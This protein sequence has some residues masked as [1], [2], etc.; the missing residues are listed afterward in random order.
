MESAIVILVLPLVAALGWVLAV[1]AREWGPHRVPILCYHR[2]LS[3]AD[4]R[5]GLVRD[6]ERMWVVYDD[7][8]AAQMA[9][10]ARA[11]FTPI[12]LDDYVA[13]RAGRFPRPPKPVAITFDDG[14]ASNYT[15]AF[16][17]LRRH[18]FKATVFVA[19]EPDEHTREQVAGVDEFLDAAQIREL[20]AHG[21]SIQSHSLT[22]PVLADLDDAAVRHELAESRAL[23]EAIT[24]RPVRHF[25]VPRGGGSA[26]VRRWIRDAGYESACGFGRGT[27]TDRSDLL[28]LP[29][30]GIERD[31][32]LGS[33]LRVLAFPSSAHYRIAATI[34]TLPAR[35]FGAQRARRLRD[36]LYTPRLAP[37][38]TTH[39]L[40]RVLL[41]LGALWVAASVLAFVSLV[42]G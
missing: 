39:V 19:L 16:P 20:A 11:G 26:R 9:E 5:A 14:Y 12:D 24:N 4:A 27:A 6:D 10:L 25:C 32:D 3:R 15:L 17:V 1:L 30:I 21:I 18:G 37:W 33:F 36:R 40:A 34:K 28:E 35:I 42:D 13:I 41:V 23:L 2:L 8:F 22:H 38:F 29:R 7:A 31:M